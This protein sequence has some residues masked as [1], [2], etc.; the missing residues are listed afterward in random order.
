MELSQC[1][2][3]GLLKARAT[4]R[5]SDTSGHGGDGGSG[6]R[7]WL[8]LLLL[9]LSSL[10][11]YCLYP[12]TRA[13]DPVHRRGLG[14]GASAYILGITV[15]LYGYV[16]TIVGWRSVFTDCVSAAP[17]REVYR[18]FP[19]EIDISDSVSVSRAQGEGPTP[20]VRSS[21]VGPTPRPG[22]ATRCGL[23]ASR[24]SK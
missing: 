24:T 2:A 12:Q 23:P 20:R 16:T 21:P 15:R 22:P 1:G 14:A 10:S 4:M 9:A 13:G 8:W 6:A 5:V 3:G 7:C 18:V 19:P 11:S 17:P